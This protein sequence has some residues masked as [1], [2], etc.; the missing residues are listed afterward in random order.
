[1]AN[2]FNAIYLGQY[3]VIDP[4]EGNQSAENAGALV[5][6]TFGGEGSPLLNNFVSISPSGDPQAE[7]DQ[8]NNLHNDQ[9]WVNNTYQLTFDA[10]A[11][12]NATITYVD[13]TSVTQPIAIF[14]DT[15]GYT[16]MAPYAS[17]S[18]FQDALEAQGIRSVSLTSLVAD[19]WLGMTSTR[20]TWNYATCFTSGALIE[21]ARG[22]RAIEALRVG[23][24]VRT[25]DHGMQ[26]IRWIGA[27]RVAAKG[28]FAPVHLQAGALGNTRPIRLSQQHRVLLSGWQVELV[29]GEP[30]ALTSARNLVNGRDITL[31][32]GGYVTYY[33]LMFDRHEIVF[34]DGLAS[35]SFHPGDAAWSMLSEPAR[36]EILGLF[37]GVKAFGLPYYGGVTRP[38]LKAHETRLVRSMQ[39]EP[40][41]QLLQM[42]V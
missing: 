27:A 7:Y 18:P 6:L 29:A 16:F 1:M 14:Q 11:Q 9:F 32:T 34:A 4:T 3:A 20:Q 24:M 2:T 22:P 30:E 38:V 37:P 31:Q 19:T 10:I 12:Y 5:G 35:E 28:A 40:E 36:L 23:D 8:D 13:G 26:A 15:N 17:A 25:L 42:A 33:H 39:T 21:T 41:A